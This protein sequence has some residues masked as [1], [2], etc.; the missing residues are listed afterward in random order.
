MTRL[1]FLP[2]DGSPVTLYESTLTPAE[3]L[4]A[5]GLPGPLTLLQQGSWLFAAP[6]N[7]LSP[8]LTPRQG[9]VLS[10]LA[11]GLTTR[12]MAIRLGV[13]QRMVGLHVAALKVRLQ[14]E[15]RSEIIRRA[16]ELNII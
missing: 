4:K 6:K 16:K 3:L 8:R 10:G 13:S 14:A 15:S 9:Q 1:L 7:Q 2:D 5:A 12:Q 11:E